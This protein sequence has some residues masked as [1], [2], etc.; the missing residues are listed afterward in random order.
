MVDRLALIETVPLASAVTYRLLLALRLTVPSLLR[1]TVNF[2]VVP[3]T[4]PA[5]F[6]DSL[7]NCVT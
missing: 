3:T 7:A 1:T 4:W 5:A 2:S 6:R